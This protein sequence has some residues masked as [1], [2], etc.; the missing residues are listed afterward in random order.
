MT[1]FVLVALMCINCASLPP[2]NLPVCGM[3]KQFED[4]CRAPIFYVDKKAKE[5]S[6]DM[7]WE[8]E[9]ICPVSKPLDE[10]PNHSKLYSCYV[11][12]GVLDSRQVYRRQVIEVK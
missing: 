1:R 6:R 12:A 3:S 11:Y 9:N 8:K 2:T 4:E 10:N 5:L 7:E